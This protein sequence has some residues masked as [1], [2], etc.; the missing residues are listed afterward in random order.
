M[1]E[2]Q[3]NN[4]YKAIM[5]S[6]KPLYK[7]EIKAFAEFLRDKGHGVTLEA[8]QEYQKHCISQSFK[9]RTINRK[10]MVAKMAFK[11]ILES[12]KGNIS[13]EQHE[14]IT[15]AMDEVKR[16]REPAA[17]DV[18]NKILT[19]DE[20]KTLLDGVEQ[21]NPEISLMIEALWR[22][23]LRISELLGITLKDCRYIG[24]GIYS[25]RVLGKGSKE[26]TTYMEQSFFNLCR[27][28][29]SSSTYL[30]KR[31]GKRR[32]SRSYVSM[33]IKRLAARFLDRRDVAAHSLR[34]SFATHSLEQGMSLEW[35]RQALG[36]SDI[37][38]TAR[39]YSHISVKPSQVI[40]VARLD[41]V[42]RM[43]A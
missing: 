2:L 20:V 10:V 34:H 3:T 27:S 28:F 15:K 23:G 6:V 41:R 32:R 1:N 42:R 5:G 40:Q 25:I 21:Y 33:N 11:C 37:Q 29:F 13:Q 12:Q 31:S 7:Y 43:A 39:Y 38:I 30:F 35:V 22:T 26:R 18:C 9:S 16:L 24:Q 19:E 36:H 4:L 17:S 14:R 8:L